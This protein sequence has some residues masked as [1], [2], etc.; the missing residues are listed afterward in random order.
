MFALSSAVL[1][2]IKFS[3]TIVDITSNRATLIDALFL[4]QIIQV[5]ADI[6]TNIDPGTNE[7]IVF[8]SPFAGLEWTVVGPSLDHRWTGVRPALC[9]CY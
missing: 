6:S 9:W 1:F 3:R 5:V 8:R 2:I 4:S 7:L